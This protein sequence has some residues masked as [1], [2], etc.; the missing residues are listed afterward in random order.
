MTTQQVVTTGRESPTVV[1]CG[2]LHGS[3]AGA[4]LPKPAAQEDADGEDKDQETHSHR[5]HRHPQLAAAG[6]VPGGAL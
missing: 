5:S 6:L 4:S 3:L 1:G 2:Y